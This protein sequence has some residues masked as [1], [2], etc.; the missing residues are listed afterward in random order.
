MAQYVVRKD[1]TISREILDQVS[2]RY[3]TVTKAVNREFWN[4]TSDILHSLYVGSYGRGTAIDVSDIDML[5]EL[6][7]EEYERFDAMKG[8][9]QSRLLQVLKE[10]IRYPYPKSDIKADGQVVVINFS[11][12]MKFEILPA[13]RSGWSSAFAYPDSNMGG[14]WKSTDPKLEQQAMREKNRQSNGLLLDTCKHIRRIKNEYYS[15]YKLSGIVI[16]SF[17]YTAIGAWQWSPYGI[18][19]TNLPGEYEKTLLHYYENHTYNGVF[20]LNLNAPGSGQ[21]IETKDSME[22]LGKVLRYMAF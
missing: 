9:G 11:D 19:G 5:V 16:D 12:G 4:S 6:P 7:R 8:N 1:E 3:H 10:A 15:S 18:K 13:F 17:V 22:C 2:V 21:R 14:N 20:P